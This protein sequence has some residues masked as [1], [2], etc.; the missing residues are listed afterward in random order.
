[1]LVFERAVTPPVTETPVSDYFWRLPQKPRKPRPEAPRSPTPI[2]R[3]EPARATAPV[4]PFRAAQVA[5]R[6]VLVSAG[7]ERFCPAD[8]AAALIEHGPLSG[9]RESKHRFKAGTL[10]IVSTASRGEVLIATTSEIRAMRRGLGTSERS[11][12]RRNGKK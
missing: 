2:P 7:A 12:R 9:S 1:V 8:L 5:D 11:E 6:T 10:M 3:E 4:V